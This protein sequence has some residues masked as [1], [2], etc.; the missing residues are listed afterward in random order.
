MLQA[1]PPRLPLTPELRQKRKTSTSCN[2]RELEFKAQLAH[3]G[4]VTKKISDFANVKE[5]YQRLAEAFNVQKSEILFCTL[6][7]HTIDMDHLLGGKLGLTDFIFVHLKGKQKELAVL[8][9]EDALGLTITDNGAGYAFVKRIKSDS[10][11]S[12]YS[13]LMVGDHIA[14]IDDVSVVGCRHYEVAKI[15]KQKER[16]NTIKLSL[17]EPIKSGFVMI[18]NPGRTK[19]RKSDIKGKETL[20]LGKGAIEIDDESTTTLI[21][22]VNELLEAFIGI[23]DL[24]LAEHLMELAHSAANVQGLARVIGESDVASFRF[25]DDFIQKLFDIVKKR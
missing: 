6:N 8:K 12:T 18:A 9:S 22:K 4:S 24:E 3:D 23:D 13:D 21:E 25:P 7:T 10:V 2:M 17:Y 11:A 1:P 19:S 14:V 20:R 5:L 15:L 16:S